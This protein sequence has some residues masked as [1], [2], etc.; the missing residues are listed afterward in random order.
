LEEKKE[1]RRYLID[2]SLLLLSAADEVEALEGLG[3]AA[4]AGL[5]GAGLDE[6][7]GTGGAL[8]GELGG[9]R[10]DELN[11]AASACI[12]WTPNDCMPDSAPKSGRGTVPAFVRGTAGSQGPAGNHISSYSVSGNKLQFACDF[13]GSLWSKMSYLNGKVR[14]RERRRRRC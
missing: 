13:S 10:E 7:G 2:S 11:F 3:G 8:G 5:P 6:V 14:D 1:D 9:G 4:F 12:C